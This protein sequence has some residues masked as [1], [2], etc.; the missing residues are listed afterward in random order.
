M[1]GSSSLTQLLQP[2]CSGVTVTTERA[3]A[4]HT[5]ATSTHKPGRSIVKPLE[6]GLGRQDVMVFDRRKSLLVVEIAQKID[7]DQ[8]L[9]G[10]GSIAGLRDGGAAGVSRTPCSA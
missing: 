4:C 5:R 2:T 7:A 6:H 9:D 10:N 1:S 3:A 8:G